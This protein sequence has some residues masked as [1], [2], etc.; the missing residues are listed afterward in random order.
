[1]ATLY[2]SGIM[3]VTTNPITEVMNQITIDQTTRVEVTLFS[4]QGAN[5]G[6]I[7]PPQTYIENCLPS[8]TRVRVFLNPGQVAT[9]QQVQ[10]KVINNS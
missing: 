6:D 1:M 8:E 3:A 2:T 10:I 5:L 4:A 7:I 9:G